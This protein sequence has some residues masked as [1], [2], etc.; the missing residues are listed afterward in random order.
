M[1]T[2]E[3]E[4]CSIRNVKLKDISFSSNAVFHKF[5]TAVCLLFL[6]QGVIVF[7]NMSSI[8]GHVDEQ[9]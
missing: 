8:R 5:V 7:M 2:S 3:D 1:V 4:C 9:K 6:T